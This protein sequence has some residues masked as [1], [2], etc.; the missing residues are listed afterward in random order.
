MKYHG[1]IGYFDTVEVKPGLFEERLIFRECYGDVLRNTKRDSLGSR[2]NPTI[3][4]TNQ[5]SIVA[6][7]YALMHFFQIR[8]IR[9]QG[10]LWSVTDVDAGQPPRLILSLGELYHEDVE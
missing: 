7:P 2:V 10:A 6:D 4:V 5:I 8:C 3:T 1:E 9:W